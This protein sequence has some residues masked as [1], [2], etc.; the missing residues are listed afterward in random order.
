MVSVGSICKKWMVF[1][2]D[3][4]TCRE[5]ERMSPRVWEEG[6]RESTGERVQRVCGPKLTNNTKQPTLGF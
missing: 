6:E 2:C 5:K 3:P 4:Y 1:G